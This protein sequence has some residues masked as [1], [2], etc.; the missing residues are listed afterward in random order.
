MP[1]CRRLFGNHAD[2]FLELRQLKSKFKAK[3]K[4][5]DSRLQRMNRDEEETDRMLAIEEEEARTGHKGQMVVKEHTPP[6]PRPKSPV[7][8]Q[9]SEDRFDCS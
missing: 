2:D 9:D 5:S 1:Q 7:Q 6:S 8:W 3:L 4:Q